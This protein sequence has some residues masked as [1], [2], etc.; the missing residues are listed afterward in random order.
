M[1]NELKQMKSQFSYFSN[2]VLSKLWSILYSEIIKKLASKM[3]KFIKKKNW[4]V[5][6]SPIPLPGL[7]PWTP[8]AFRLRTLA[9]WLAFEGLQNSWLI[10]NHA[11]KNL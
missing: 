1:R 5:A 7:R 9:H 6:S 3:E 10:L 11:R 2:F 4:W 8:H